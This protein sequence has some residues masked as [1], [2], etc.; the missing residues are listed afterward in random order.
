MAYLLL[1]HL[2]THHLTHPPLTNPLTHPL[3]HL[4]Y[5][6]FGV[7]PCVDLSH[8]C[9]REHDS[10][11]TNN[12]GRITPFYY[13]FIYPCRHYSGMTNNPGHINV[14]SLFTPVV[15]IQICQLWSRMTNNPG[16]ITPF[17]YPF[18][19][20]CRHYSGMTNNPGHINVQSLFTP[21]VIIQICQLW[22]RM[23]NNPGH[24]TPFYDP[25]IYPCHTLPLPHITLAISTPTNTPYINNTLKYTRT[26]VPEIQLSPTEG[27]FCAHGAQFSVSRQ[28]YHDQWNPSW[29]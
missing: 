14:Q 27:L 16:H 24:I 20:P 21:V 12:P 28:Q 9:V 15:I 10:G 3:S 25:F 8:A 11:M 2:L 1:I 19:Y 22:S 13:P 18:I 26:L 7:Q 23:T 4:Y 6:Q 5:R 29:G 17:Y